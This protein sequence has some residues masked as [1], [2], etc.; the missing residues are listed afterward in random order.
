MNVNDRGTKKW[1]AMMMPEHIKMIN[2]LWA[3]D[4][5]KEKPILDEQQK[6]EIDM[7]LQLAI[8]DDLTV[9]VE[10]YTD[11]ACHT[12]KGKLLLVDSLNRRLHFD[13]KEIEIQ[14][15]DIIDVTIL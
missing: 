6:V 8:K 12:E 4:D 13:D 15:D 1:T 2:D 9:E 11:Y 7:K 3:E 14:L 5:K 10:Y